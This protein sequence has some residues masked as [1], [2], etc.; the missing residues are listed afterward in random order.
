MAADSFNNQNSL[1]NS[2]ATNSAAVTPHDTNTLSPIP[3]ALYVGT[4]GTV[5]AKLQADSATVSY[6]N[7]AS[8]TVLPIRAILVHTDTTASNIVALW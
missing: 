4:G 5:V 6:V 8:G 7:V 1:I 2:P 3:R